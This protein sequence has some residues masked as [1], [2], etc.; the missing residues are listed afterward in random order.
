M[1]FG[2]EIKDKNM[3]DKNLLSAYKSFFKMVNDLNFPLFSSYEKILNLCKNDLYLKYEISN[4]I[5]QVFPSPQNTIYGEFISNNI[6]ELLRKNNVVNGFDGFLAQKSI[7]DYKLFLDELKRTDDSLKEK[8]LL[9]DDIMRDRA[10]RF[11]TKPIHIDGY[12]LFFHGT[13]RENFLKIEKSGCLMY[14]PYEPA[15]HD[16][17]MNTIIELE[18]KRVYLSDNFDDSI[19]YALKQSLD[20]Y[21]IAVNMDGCI[22][23]NDLHISNRHFWTTEP[24]QKDR[25]VNIYH[26]TVKDNKITITDKDG[27]IL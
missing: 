14:K 3:W 2:S 17:F 1:S 18:K 20:G 10:R 21:I 11:D 7:T 5:N 6:T 24:I 23:H 27:V 22:L 19:Y 25:F 16:S 4:F 12:N 9:V 15:I 26:I 8:G 13:P